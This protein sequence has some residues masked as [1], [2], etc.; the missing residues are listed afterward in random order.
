[1][2]SRHRKVWLSFSAVNWL[3]VSSAVSSTLL[4]KISRKTLIPAILYW[5][6]GLLYDKPTLLI[7]SICRVLVV[8]YWIPQSF[9]RHW[10]N[11]GFRDRARFGNFVYIY[12][13]PIQNRSTSLM[14]PAV[15]VPST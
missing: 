5:D 8:Y 15:K 14:R 7:V 4:V 9:S 10:I 3:W 12:H 11:L 13:L 2:R 6:L 1:M